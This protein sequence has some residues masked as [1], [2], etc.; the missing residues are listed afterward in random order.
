MKIRLHIYGATASSGRDPLIIETLESH[1]N[2]PHSVALLWTNDQQDAEPSDNT[3]HSQETDIHA[4]GRIGTNS[5]SNRAAVTHALGR[6]ATG[7][8]IFQL[9]I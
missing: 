7:I 4:P 2:T 1:S 3:Q 5:P 6:A 8:G 9:L